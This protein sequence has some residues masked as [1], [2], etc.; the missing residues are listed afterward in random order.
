MKPHAPGAIASLICG[1]LGLMLCGMPLVGLG[2]GIAAIIAARRARRAL[3]T[4]PDLYLQS[5]VSAAGMI[6]GIIGTVFS[7]LSTLWLAVVLAVI[8][9]VASAAS[10][11]GPVAPAPGPLL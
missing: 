6:C 5:G 2:L 1:I 3:A 8:A 4:H 9:A 10:G 11:A 7:A